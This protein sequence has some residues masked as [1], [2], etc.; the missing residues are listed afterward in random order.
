MAE[1][2]IVSRRSDESSPLSMTYSEADDA[3]YTSITITAEE[4]RS[5]SLNSEDNLSSLDETKTLVAAENHTHQCHKADGFFYT[6]NSGKRKFSPNS[7]VLAWKK[8]THE[9]IKKE[10]KLK[11]R[12]YR[13]PQG[14][15][16]VDLMDPSEL[17]VARKYRLIER[18]GNG[19]FGELY[20]A[21]DIK[22]GKEV[23][24]KVEY[25]TAAH[26]MLER[27]AKVYKLLAGTEGIPKIRYY[28]SER[29]VNVL[30]LD[31]LG[32][33]LE[34]LLNFCT[35][36]F[37]LKTTLMLALQML[38]RLECVHKKGYI[39][40][41]IK[42]DNFLMGLN[43]RRCLVFLIDFGLA[44]KYYDPHTGKH[45]EYCQKRELVG[46]PRYSS[47]RSH[48]AEQGRRDDLESLGYMLIYFRHGRL[49]WQGVRAD[50]RAQ[51]FEQIGEMKASI[52]LDSLC[53]QM[54]EEFLLFLR[55]CR[56]LHFG[57]I[58]DY[59]YLRRMLQS[60]LFRKGL[61]NDFL[62]DWV[63]PKHLA[64]HQRDCVDQRGR[65]IT[66]NNVNCCSCSYHKYKRR[67]D[68]QRDRNREPHPTCPL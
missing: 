65:Q 39:H 50:T 37:T 8:H 60:I 17:I 25:I 58:P 15:P 20:Q 66:K 53:N 45:I 9:F 44:K 27:E 18:I 2:A 33:S 19:S 28:G 46:T 31:L 5:P 68:H 47:V 12:R 36:T 64:I 21:V 4:V 10:K 42:P 41:D 48:F 59:V 34:D 57:D 49:P 54:P 6:G 38:T 63:D 61:L 35:R 7:I 16:K 26:S 56:C 11:K 52:K 1:I 30:V 67:L 62:F 29:D 24:V 23:A 14:T 51:K 55:Y 40:R 22:K 32:P 13:R 3:T 43:G